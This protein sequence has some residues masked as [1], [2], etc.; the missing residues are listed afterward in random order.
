M[1]VKFQCPSC[2]Q[3]LECGEELAG[4]SIECP[5]CGV[6]LIV[7]SDNEEVGNESANNSS[8]VSRKKSQKKTKAS[9]K[10]EE[11]QRDEI[12]SNTKVEMEFLSA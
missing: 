7:P 12:Q 5:Q 6:A 4:Q 9:H 3:K 10:L 11:G 2:S 8:G 1:E